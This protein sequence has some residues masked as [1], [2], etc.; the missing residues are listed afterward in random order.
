MFAC[1]L[2]RE[3]YEPKDLFNEL[4]PHIE[5]RGGTLSGDDTVIEKPYSEPNLTEFIGSFWSGNQH[6][7]V[8]GINLITLYYTDIKGKSVP[9][10][11]RLYNKREEKTKNDYFREM[12]A[13][14]L[15]WGLKPQIVTGDSWYSSRENLKFLRNQKVG[16]MMGI[17]KNRQVA[18][19]AG[20]YTAVK[21]LEIPPQ[22]QVV[23]LKDF[24]QVKVFQKKFK[25]DS[26]RYYIMFW[27]DIKE[28]EAITR[29]DFLTTHSIHWGIECYHRAI[30]QLCGIKK[31]MVR[32]SA[33]IVTH[34]FCSIRAFVQL[35]LMRAEALIDN[36]YEIQR[37][38][39]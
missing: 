9:V 3:R 37:N 5:L 32:S 18:I 31:F 36:W 8:K 11:Y 28:T 1:F 33:A 24:G 19:T 35:E 30:K 15:L 21:E 25:N 14:V 29:I 10:N 17:A 4:K 12:V 23:H 27:P 16:F 6:R 20:K 39:S 2:L 34:F 38:L 7:P 26:E 22:G 13:Q